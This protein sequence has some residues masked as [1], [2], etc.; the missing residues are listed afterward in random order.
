MISVMF[1]S[2]HRI[3]EQYPQNDWSSG[4]A[5]RRSAVINVVLIEGE[6]ESA[7][8]SGISARNRNEG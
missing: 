4:G 7:R 8:L 3:S 2:E 5:E 6:E 1:R